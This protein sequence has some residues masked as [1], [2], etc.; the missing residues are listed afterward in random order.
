MITVEEAAAFLREL[1]L[2]LPT[3]ILECLVNKAASIQACLDGA[4]YSE[5]DQKLIYYY[6]VGML[7]ISSGARRIKSQGAPSG[8]SRSFEYGTLTEQMRQLRNSLRVLDT[9]GCTT[10]LQPA[11]PGGQAGMWVGLGVCA[12]E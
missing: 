3:A 6:L 11:D 4:G 1:G 10:E 8:A 2:T 12:D 9:S 5:C 7:A